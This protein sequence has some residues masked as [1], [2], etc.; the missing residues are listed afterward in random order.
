MLLDQDVR[1]AEP[2]RSTSA[3]AVVKGGGELG[4][5]VALALGRAG[6][7]VVVTELPRPTVLRPQL[8]LAEAAFAGMVRR[9]D[10]CAVRASA[11]SEAVALLR[12]PATI[13]LYLGSSIELLQTI[14]PALV[15]DAR[16]RRGVEPER[17]RHEAPRV[18]GLGPRLIAGEHVDLVIET[19]PGSDLGRVVRVGAARP[20]VPLPRRAHGTAEEYVRAPSAGL[21][22]TTRAIGDLVRAGDVL[23]WLDGEALRA[24]V[25]GCVRGLVHDAVSAPAGLKV[26]TVHPGD[27][28]RKEAGISH[29]AKTVASVV[30][31]LAGETAGDD[32][33]AS[34]QPSAALL[35]A[36]P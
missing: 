10:W 5:A 31:T 14:R 29:R 4:T 27:W 13:P 36:M 3:T 7:H 24:P 22:R 28:Q 12:Q 1:A 26:A 16:M 17:Q 18:I 23:G 34:N 11:P 25:D 35:A 15:V 6:W 32:G 8:S 30:A 2:S 20:H 21:W 19:C 33:L 9:D